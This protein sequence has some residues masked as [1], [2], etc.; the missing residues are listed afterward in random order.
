MDGFRGPCWDWCDGVALLDAGLLRARVAGGEEGG[1]GFS[2]IRWPGT[3]PSLAKLQLLSVIGSTKGAEVRLPKGDA[4]LRGTDLVRTHPSSPGFA[5][6]CQTYRSCRAL[7][8]LGGVALTLTLSL[9]TNRLD[10]SPRV[11]VRSLLDDAHQLGDA[12]VVLGHSDRVA[13]APLP[14]DAAETSFA[15]DRSGATLWFAPPFLEKGV[16]RRAQFVAILAPA[17]LV[18]ETVQAALVELATAPLPLT[19]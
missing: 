13:I 15:V 7:P 17:P 8:R 14:D 10:G 12:P 9:Q 2:D 18:A 11:A 6:R 1:A 5:Y 19:T 4:Y 3:D 16:I